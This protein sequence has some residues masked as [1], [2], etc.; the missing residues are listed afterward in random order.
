MNSGHARF[1]LNAHRLVC[2]AAVA[3]FAVVAEVP[4]AGAYASARPVA[5]S[6]ITGSAA[7][8]VAVA[9]V[10]H[11]AGAWAVG[12]K[13]S[14]KAS[15]PVGAALTFHWNGSD[16]SQVKAPSPDGRV[17]LAAVSASSP[18]NAWAV[19]S[20]DGSADKNLFLHWNGKIWK[21]V[22]GPDESNGT[23]TGIAV[24]SPSDAWA[25][26]SYQNKSLQTR[27][28]ALHWNGKTWQK[29]ASPD[30]VNGDDE[31][32]GVA[33]VSA[34]SVW[35]VGDGLDTATAEYQ[36]VI[37]HWNGKTWAR[38]PSPA[39]ATLGTHLAGVA[40]VSGLDAWAVGQYDNANNFA[41]PLILHWNGH[42]W[43]RA[44]VPGPS[45]NT[46]ALAAAAAASPSSAWAVGWGPC[47]S[48]AENCPSR[49]LI[50]HWNGH[51]WK[52]ASSVSIN[53]HA[54]QN[55]LTGATAAGP[56]AWAVGSY[57]P[58]VG[59]TPTRALLLHWNGK[60]WQKQ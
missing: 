19:G 29:V 16:W 54:D 26:G 53:D 10:P 5:A 43:R 55:S 28:L 35:A 27:T 50:L 47:T 60:T 14:A 51:T 34:T 18:A 8:L 42:T 56:D 48:G 45:T 49:S 33:A 11:T 30:P 2:V 12:I 17:S 20:Y 7:D 46:E 9:A 39:V 58:P 25:V 52:T 6:G 44:A 36:T 24:I 59:E 57:F 21:H 15:C 40:A 1:V 3:V 23:L 32:G 13:C 22:N 38:S 37:L 4:E 31:L 41:N